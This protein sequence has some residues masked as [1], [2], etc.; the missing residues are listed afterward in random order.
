M[1]IVITGICGFVGS[2][3][4]REFRK[5]QPDVTII[6]IDNLAR[7]GSETNRV[8]F[9]GDGVQVNH[10]DIRLASDV[11]A[12]PAADW[13]IDAA[14]NPSV[15]AGVDGKSS[16]R[17][18]VEHNLFGTVNLLEYCRRHRAGFTLLSTSRVYSIPPLASLPMVE[19]ENRFSLAK[20]RALP[21][22]I[23][24]AGITEMFSTESPVSLYGATKRASEML[25]LEYGDSFDFPVWI[26]RCG[27]LAG[28]GQF[29]RPDQG[30]LAYWIH[31]WVQKKPVAYI[32]FGGTGR[33]V[34]DAFHPR[35][36]M[37]LLLAQMAFPGGMTS[38]A[39]RIVNVG[40]G[41]ENSFSLASLSSWCA[42]RFGL[43]EV[44]QIPTERPF[45]VPW[46]V[47]DSA[48]AGATW[49][50][51]VETPL[52]TVLDE[53]SVHAENNPDWL[54]RSASAT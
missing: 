3:L 49:D 5:Q 12:L 46:L 1:K 17:Q 8:A 9:V 54:H 37:S 34:R 6:G 4:A 35:D 23:S 24:A 20:G 25:A 43:R 50:W 45:D 13:V 39:P 7:P 36:L 44:S 11:D 30:I 2:V 22:G 31:S 33:Q 16:P 27:L 48:L 14:A 41:V 21:P 47:F 40:G 42:A 38:G 29:G 10:G 52:G 26:N 15:M 18:V 53:I 19:D 32:G 51:K 28:A